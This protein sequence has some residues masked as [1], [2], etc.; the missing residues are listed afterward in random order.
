[1]FDLRTP[2]DITI[3]TRD[4]RGNLV[5]ASAV[6]DIPAVVMSHGRNGIG[7]FS[8]AGIRNLGA[9]S[10]NADERTNASARGIAFVAR[11]RSDNTAA[12]GGEF[13]DLVVWISPNVLNN[14]M[15]SAGTLPR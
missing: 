13:D 12:P 3:G 9:S 1:M 14:R 10:T 15:V 7:G 6:N 11:T 5:T 2:R 8:D 4:T